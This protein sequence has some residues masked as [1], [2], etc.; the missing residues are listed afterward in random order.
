L[1]PT[2]AQWASHRGGRLAEQIELNEIIASLEDHLEDLKLNA[3]SKSSSGEDTMLD[4]L[5]RE[6]NVNS[7]ILP[8]P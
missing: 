4:V 1:L 3:I 6:L 7:A 5:Q 8:R 2:C